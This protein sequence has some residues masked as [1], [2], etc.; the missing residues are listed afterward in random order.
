MTTATNGVTEYGAR[1]YE[2]EALSKKDKID[3]IC[4]L[5]NDANRKQLGNRTHE[6]LTNSYARMI[7]SQYDRDGNKLASWLS[8][9]CVPQR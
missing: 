9:N 1:M 8:S 5:V 6:Q 7:A 4:E 2:F 3:L